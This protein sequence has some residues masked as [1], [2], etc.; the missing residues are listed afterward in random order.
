MGLLLYL[1]RDRVLFYAFVCIYPIFPK[2]DMKMT[3][4]FQV[5]IIST[6]V[7]YQLTIPVRERL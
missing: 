3:V 5:Y 4:S 2:M 6:F 7:K 1:K